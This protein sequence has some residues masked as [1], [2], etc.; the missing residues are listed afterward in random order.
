MGGKDYVI[1]K[2]FDKDQDGRLNT[3]ERN[4]AMEAVKNVRVLLI[5]KLLYQGYESN[6]VW[7]VEVSGGARPYRLL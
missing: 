3:H 7:N 5:I 6:F 4:S 1:A 2:Q